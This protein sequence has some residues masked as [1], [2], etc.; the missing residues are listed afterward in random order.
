MILGLTG[1]EMA[2]R[3]GA[4]G[5]FGDARRATMGTTLVERVVETGSLVIRKLGGTRA[6]EIAIHRFL[7]A[8]SVTCG[9][10]V[11]TL[12]HRTAAACQGRRI[13]AA[14]D[15]T[16][17]NFAGREERRRG[18]GPAGDGVSAG[19]FLHPV[20]AIDSETEAVLGLLDTKI[21]TRSDEF[22]ATPVRE[23]ALEDK[24]SMRWLAGAA[25]A[26][27][28]LTDAASVVVVAD[29][30]SDIYA[31]FARRPASI[32]LIVR[33][34]QDRVLDDGGRLFA[35]SEAWPELTRSEV[36]VAPSR[37][38]VAARIAIVALRAGT[39]EVCRPRPGG[40]A[41]GPEHL[42]LTMVEAREIDAPSGSSPLLWQLLTTLK[43]TNADEA[44][45]I[46]RLYRLRWRIEEVFRSLKSDGMRLEE[47]QMHDAGRLFKLALVGLAAATRTVQLVDARDGSPRPATDVIDATLMPAAEAIAPTLE[48][49]TV[50]QQNPHPRHS[51]AWL[52]WIVARL[53][54]WNCYYKPPGPK[55]MR[56]GWARFA[57]MAAGFIL[58]TQSN[59]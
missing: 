44:A 19:F 15:T 4:L 17:I 1:N 48:G 41:E 3:G 28:R 2:V 29:R 56:A 55:T 43:V 8:P 51:L 45:E 54:G 59:V 14:Q 36:R 35:A 46:V 9:E 42:S 33:A 40:E 57:S 25:R 13:V 37:T 20:I 32:D 53:G 5:H 50:R 31:G 52:S 21:W 26:A 47:T 38:G 24:E 12:A 27:E 49:K 6:R 11:E 58:A 23:R 18:L 22:D 30:E 39:V 7:S 10:M 16:E 34:A